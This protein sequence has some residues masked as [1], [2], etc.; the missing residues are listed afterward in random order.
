M[1]ILSPA[2][3]CSLKRQTPAWFLPVSNTMVLFAEP[4]A[5]GIALET[6]V[7]ERTPCRR[8]GGTDCGE[9]DPRLS[10]LGLPATTAFVQLEASKPGIDHAL[11]PA[12]SSLR[13][14]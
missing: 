11:G 4:G 1:T 5:V 6:T 3:P 7:V 13:A 10:V 14:S 8:I 12:G 9:S 2:L